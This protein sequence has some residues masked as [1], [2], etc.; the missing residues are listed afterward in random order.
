MNT[1]VENPDA[2]T[3]SALGD[4]LEAAAG[5]IGTARTRATTS[6]SSAARKVGS[7]I[8]SG[9][10]HSAYGVSYGVVFSAVFMKEFLPQHSA[11][12]RGLALHG[13]LAEDRGELVQHR[14][15]APGP[16]RPAGHRGV[17]GHAG[18]EHPQIEADRRRPRRR[19]GSGAGQGHTPA[20]HV[21]GG[22]SPPSARAVAALWPLYGSS[23]AAL[24]PRPAGALPITT[25]PGYDET[26]R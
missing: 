9:A 21:C 13:D 8:G 17:T 2:G 4:A 22:P 5:S 7:V 10:Y 24:W 15:Q 3:L 18:I 14:Q 11:I 6:I 19:A 23:V 20:Y 26:P 1:I 16:R 25:A 12:R